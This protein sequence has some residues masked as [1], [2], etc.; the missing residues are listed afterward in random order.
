MI[1]AWIG[2]LL[3]FTPPMA[4]TES[5]HHCDRVALERPPAE[6]DFQCYAGVARQQQ[7]SE[8]LTHLAALLVEHPE[9]GRLWL[10]YGA[11]QAD[12]G[13]NSIDTFQ[14]AVSTLAQQDLPQYQI[15]AQLNLAQQF[16]DHGNTRA[17]WRILDEAQAVAKALG[18]PLMSA[19]VEFARLGEVARGLDGDLLTAYEHARVS[20]AALPESSPYS[21]RQNGLQLMARAARALGRTE[22]AARLA[23]QAAEIAEQAGDPHSALYAWRS[24]ARNNLRAELRGNDPDAIPRFRRKLATLLQRAI[25]LH[26]PRIELSVRIELAYTAPLN[27]QAPL[28]NACH[29]LAVRLDAEPAAASCLAGL[30]GAV[31]KDEPQRAAAIAAELVRGA[32]ASGSSRDLADALRVQGRVANNRG[33]ID[34]AWRAWSSM[35]DA[36]EQTSRAPDNAELRGLLHAN[37]TDRYRLVAGAML[38]HSMSAETI[39]RALDA[40]ERMRGREAMQ[41]HKRSIGAGTH[42]HASLNLGEL[43]Q[44]VPSD[45]A[46]VVVQIGHNRDVAGHPLGG[47]WVIVVTKEGAR[48]YRIPGARTVNPAIAMVANGLAGSPSNA[49]RQASAALYKMLVDE[50]FKELPPHVQ[51]LVVI[52]DGQLHRLPLG[53]LEYNGHPLFQRFSISTAPSVSLWLRLQHSEPLP[54][55]LVALANPTLPRGDRFHTANVSGNL[56]GAAAESRFA[57]KLIAGDSYVLSG[58]DAT[59]SALKNISGAGIVHIATHAVIEPTRPRKTRVLLAS[60]ESEDGLVYL[61]EL[62][63][64]QQP[65]SLI[66][67]AACQGADGELLAGEGT[68]SPARAVLLAG[69]RTV[70]AGLWPIED[71]EAAAF[72]VEFYSALDCGYPVDAAVA[73]AQTR[74]REAGAPASAWAGFIVIGDGS[75]TIAPRR[76][77]RRWHWIML[78]T[79]LGALV[80]GI[81]APLA[82]R[83]ARK[84]RSAQLQ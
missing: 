47:S 74:R 63:D 6:R 64:L 21:V 70:V 43:T 51:H 11:L 30:A 24:A 67:L 81:G 40:M 34:A 14:T 69:A 38:T 18:N 49:T 7:P 23:T 59:E 29:K 75:A 79:L 10:T 84:T 42:P 19:I 20:Y 76:G 4:V 61:G 60:D 58:D 12:F 72:F 53:A 78:A 36:F 2:V 1:A 73:R 66:V 56:E 15:Q 52:P 5:L 33:D 32:R 13:A 62:S 65:G 44:A 50:A 80:G 57:A 82:G 25:I 8:V 54:R 9:N 26:N 35:F 68:L 48:A 83:A 16:S 55:R 39:A 17:A 45:T 27:D 71:A 3:A 41:F 37:G 28:W 22:T 46:I 31:M 77:P